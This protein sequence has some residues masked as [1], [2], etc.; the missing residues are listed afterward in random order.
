VSGAAA[1]AD[2]RTI[3]AR[4][5]AAG[6]HGPGAMSQTV[7]EIMNREVFNVREHDGVSDVLQYFVALGITGAPVVDKDD[8]LIGFVSWRD[9]LT[10]EDEGTITG[11]M[12]APVDSIPA[13]CL[14]GHAARRMCDDDRHHLVVV[15][16][17][18]RP[19]GFVGSLDVLRGVTGE[20]VSHPKAFPHWDPKTGLPWTDENHLDRETIN[21]IAPDGPGLF[22]LIKPNKGLPNE[23]VWSQAVVNVRERLLELLLVPLAAPPHLADPLERRVLWFRAARASSVHALA[24]AVGRAET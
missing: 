11:R 21:R 12:T 24:E 4:R 7:A 1:A 19:I 13:D 9:L 23:V 3:F 18:N 10:G 20:P 6:V 22:V 2:G 16:D 17:D 5:R 14:I 15:D 8:R